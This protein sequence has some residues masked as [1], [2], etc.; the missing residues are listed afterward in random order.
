M[1]KR[2][3]DFTADALEYYARYLS[4]TAKYNE[5]DHALTIAAVLRKTD[6]RLLK[7]G[8]VKKEME[9]RIAEAAKE[10]VHLTGYRQ[11][12]LDDDIGYFYCP[13][14]PNLP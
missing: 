8:Q 6:V 11:L 2:D 5:A 3:E 9:S 7:K 12:Q 1:K 4:S 10:G 14:I 13:Y